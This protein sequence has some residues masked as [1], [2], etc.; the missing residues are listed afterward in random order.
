MGASKNGQMSKELYE[1]AKKKHEGR[2]LHA[3]LV[4]HCQQQSN[5]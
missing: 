3:F 5:L 2:N 4:E 1:W